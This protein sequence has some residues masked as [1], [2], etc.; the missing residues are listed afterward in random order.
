MA[1]PPEYNAKTL[2]SIAKQA[3]ITDKTELAMFTA[4]MSHE[5]GGF[6]YDKE[7]GDEAYLSQY[8]GRQD[9]GNTQPGDGPRFAGRGYIQLT[10]RANYEHFGAKLAAN[11]AGLIKSLG[12]EPSPDMLI[13]NPDL[14]KH[15]QLAGIIAVE[16]WK[17]R[18]SPEAARSGDVAR[19]TKQI[20]GGHNGLEDRIQR[21]EKYKNDPVLLN[22]TAAAASAGITLPQEI[23]VIASDFTAANDA[24]G[25]KLSQIA[26]QYN[27]RKIT[28]PKQMQDAMND[29]QKRTQALYEQ[30]N[31]PITPTTWML[32]MEI[33]P[34]AAIG[35]LTAPDATPLSQ[36]PGMRP[37]SLKA[38]EA[39]LK[40]TGVAAPQNLGALNVSQAKQLIDQSYNK[41]TNVATTTV[42]QAQSGTL[43]AQQQQDMSFFT[44][45]SKMMGPE[46]GTL[47]SML[48]GILSMFGMGQNQEGQFA[49]SNIGGTLTPPA[50][51]TSPQ[52]LNPQA[53][54][55]A[56]AA[57]SNLRTQQVTGA[58]A[59]ANAPATPTTTPAVANTPA[60]AVANAPANNPAKVAPQR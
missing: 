10:G 55:E 18:V 46:M 60:P 9:L 6:Q 44:E 26:K 35:L 21:F 25:Q 4:Q 23:N 14:A 48:F 49:A 53:Q 2:I 5:S 31:V 30:A 28:N 1:P 43:P 54:Q 39:M 32:G 37:E 12:F 42:Q 36:V 40:E 38:F 8:N 52:A 24:F 19:V 58:A 56:L 51:T 20:N 27:E 33:G 41:K 15:P 57:A 11:H 29:L 7:I 22:T 17:E 3:G 59:P 50:Q 34:R 16:Y 13:K 47:F 45:I